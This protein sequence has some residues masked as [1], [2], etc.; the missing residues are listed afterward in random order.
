[1]KCVATFLLLACQVLIPGAPFVHRVSAQNPGTMMPE[2][3]SAKAK[4]ILAQ[5]IDALGGPAYLQVRERECHGRRA[6]FGHNGELTGYMDF[7]DFWRYPDKHRTE[8]SKKGNIADVFNG[9]HG[10][11]LDRSGVS[12]KPENAVADFK[13]ALQH[14]A[15]NF[16]RVRLQ[17]KGLNINFVGMDV[18]DMKEVDWVEASDAISTMRLAVERSSHLLIRS[19]VMSTD[20]DTGERTQETTLYS[21]YHRKDG[22]MVPQQIVRERDGRRVFQAF[23]ETCTINPGLPDN[24]FTAAALE[25]RYAE[26]GNK[27]DKEKYKNAID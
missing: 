9:D 8:Y 6:Q 25:K 12:E 27:K 15:D 2:Q 18:V 7:R 26:V 21:S 5:L 24:F 22:V 4:E 14:S 1:M 13:Q 10:W 17:E 19:V 20:E 23:Y 16:L 3:S 11:T